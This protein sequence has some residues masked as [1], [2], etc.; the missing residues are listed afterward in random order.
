MIVD[1]Q[2][3]WKDTYLAPNIISFRMNTTTGTPELI[4]NRK[5]LAGSE[6]YPFMDQIKKRDRRI[7]PFLTALPEMIADVMV[8]CGFMFSPCFVR[9]FV[10]SL[11]RVLY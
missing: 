9:A 8:S 10:R 3:I 2:N 11:C 1:Q 7:I 4:A 5:A 6:N